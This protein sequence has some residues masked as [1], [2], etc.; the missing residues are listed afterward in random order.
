MIVTKYFIGTEQECEE[1]R[2]IIETALNIEHPCKLADVIHIPETL[3]YVIGLRDYQLSY[4][5][6][7]QMTQV[8]DSCVINEE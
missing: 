5:S 2:S 3:E 8:F 4:L 1:V 6:E 7:E